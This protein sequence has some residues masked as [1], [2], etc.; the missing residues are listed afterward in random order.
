MRD[1]ERMA[2]ARNRGERTCIAAAGRE[3]EMGVDR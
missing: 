3:C 1:E 2:G